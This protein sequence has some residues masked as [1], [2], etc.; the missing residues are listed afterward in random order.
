MFV[1]PA[2][3]LTPE[4]DEPPGTLPP[5]PPPVRDVALSKP[6]PD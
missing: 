6:S 3:A 2:D 4:R 1:G 5:E